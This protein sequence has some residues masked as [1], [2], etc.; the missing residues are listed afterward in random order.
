[1]FVIVLSGLSIGIG[2]GSGA[3]LLVL[4]LGAAFVTRRIKHRRAR[5]LKQ[6]RGHLLQQ[7]VSQKADIAEKMIIPLIEL[8]KPQ[9]IATKLA[10]LAEVDM[11]LSTRAFYPTS[12][13]SQ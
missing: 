2:V 8:E 10:S 6:N 13:S 3:G 12:M 5:M 4:A 7:L 11:V 9:I 1:L